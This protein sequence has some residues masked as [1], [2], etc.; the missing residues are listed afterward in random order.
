M[1]ATRTEMRITVSR[2]NTVLE[3]KARQREKLLVCR[4]TRKTI[5]RDATT[6]NLSSEP[7]TGEGEIRDVR[8]YVHTIYDTLQFVGYVVS[9]PRGHQLNR[10]NFTQYR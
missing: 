8:T 3:L 6:L 4:S 5:S 1:H 2:R 10:I 9:H 7:K